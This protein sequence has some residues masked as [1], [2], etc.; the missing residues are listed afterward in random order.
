MLGKLYTAE[1]RPFYLD[2]FSPHTSKLQASSQFNLKFY[3]SLQNSGSV[4]F[5]DMPNTN[6]F[7]QWT[8]YFSTSTIVTLLAGYE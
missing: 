5:A 2:K 3:M 8:Q 6:T 4:G 1:E 7:F